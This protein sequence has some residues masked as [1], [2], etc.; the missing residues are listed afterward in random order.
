MTTENQ[1]TVEQSLHSIALSMIEINKELK[2]MRRIQKDTLR[3]MKAQAR[4]EI[5]RPVLRKPSFW[6]RFWGTRT[7]KVWV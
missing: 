4:Q 7:V 3:C 5:M 1:P 6:T 2:E